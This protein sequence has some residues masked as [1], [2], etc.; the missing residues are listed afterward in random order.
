[1]RE[2]VERSPPFHR[3]FFFPEHTH[4]RDGNTN[5]KRLSHLRKRAPDVCSFFFFLFLSYPPRCGKHNDKSS[6]SSGCCEASRDGGILV[7][8]PH[9]KTPRGHHW[10][11]RARASRKARSV[12]RRK[13]HR[14]GIRVCMVPQGDVLPHFFLLLYFLPRSCQPSAPSSCQEKGKIMGFYTE[15]PK[16]S[17]I[18]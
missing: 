6:Q 1:M 4:E 9:G 10:W 11:Q 3:F 7:V 14:N 15:S 17:I 8:K 18:S 2:P 12:G 13:R 5:E 16:L